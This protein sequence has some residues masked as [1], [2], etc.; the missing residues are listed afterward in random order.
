MSTRSGL[1]AGADAEMAPWGSAGRVPGD[2]PAMAAQVVLAVT[3]A[4]HVRIV[5]LPT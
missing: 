5:R 4:V 1:P 2:L 3:R